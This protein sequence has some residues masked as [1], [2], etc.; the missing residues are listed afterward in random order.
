[1]VLYFSNPCNTKYTINAYKKLYSNTESLYI[2]YM[3]MQYNAPNGPRNISNICIVLT[4]REKLS[5]LGIVYDH[6]PP[7]GPYWRDNQPVAAEG[8]RA[9]Q[10][11]N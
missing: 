3:H 4:L 9:W 5:G 2:Y 7:G 1:M 6:A 8:I 10:V 11:I